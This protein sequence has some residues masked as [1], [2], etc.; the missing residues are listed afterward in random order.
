MKKLRYFLEILLSFVLPKDIDTAKI[1]SMTA[2]QMVEKIPPSLE[3]ISEDYM[4]LFQYKNKIA[5][6]AIWEIKYRGNKKIAE[7]FSKLLYEFILDN[8]SDKV[9]FSNF[10]KPLLMPIPISVGGL[11]ERGF[12]QCELIISEILKIDNKN[13]FETVF[14]A[15]KKTKETP[16]QSKLKNRLERLK[17]LENCF[18]T[19]KEKVDGQYIILID[20]VITTGSTMKEASKTLK[21][22]GAKKVI[23]FALA[24]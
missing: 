6:K 5:K 21:E 2:E 7:K 16:H 10:K 14:D 23:G 19:K 3:I 18:S 24:H 15:L 9:S 17:N 8:L 11:K 13:N 12:N 4:A 1:E 20:D 22:K